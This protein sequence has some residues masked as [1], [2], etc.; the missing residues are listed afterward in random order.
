M[1]GSSIRT[2]SVFYYDDLRLILKNHYAKRIYEY[3]INGNPIFYRQKLS[4]ITNLN[5]ETINRWLKVIHSVDSGFV[6]NTN[7]EKIGLSQIVIKFQHSLKGNLMDRIQ[8][9]KE[10]S[11]W[12]LRWHASSA[13]PDIKTLLISFSP[14]NPT[15]ISTI[16]K[17][18]NQVGTIEDYF[19][20]DIYIPNR[21]VD[22]YF[23][24][25]YVYRICMNN[26]KKLSENLKKLSYKSDISDKAVVE[27]RKHI[28]KKRS[29]I[30]ILDLLLISHLEENALYRPQELASKTKSTVLKVNRHLRKHIL[31]PHLISGTRI[32]YGRAIGRTLVL[33]AFWG[34]DEVPLV[35]RILNELSKVY[36]FLSGVIDS[37]NGKFMFILGVP[38]HEIFEYTEYIPDTFNEIFR[39][40]ESYQLDKFTIKSYT[41]PYIPFDRFN[42]EWSLSEE[43][44]VETKESLMKKGL[45]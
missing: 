15:A 6:V 2:D 5:I 26:W 38:G 13:F 43:V 17:D 39:Y 29:K 27:K 41:I 10:R 45:L 31:Y 24:C 25:D 11:K 18:Y 1:N 23:E 40:I 19:V 7:F 30:D 34:R 21:M 42:K 28:K 44:I 33:Y 3:I 20:A 9:L 32:R 37:T 12:F 22:E 4:R 14:M 16:I 35:L 8:G 36:G